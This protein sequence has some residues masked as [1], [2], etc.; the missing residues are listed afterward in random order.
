MVIDVGGIS[1]GILRKPIKNLY[2]RVS[3]S[4]GEVTV[5]APLT[6]SLQTIRTQL[7]AKR[8]WI[9][10][11]HTRV[12]ERLTSSSVTMEHGAIHYF[13]GKSYSL[14]V[15]PVVHLKGIVIEGDCI[16][17]FLE[18]CTQDERKKALQVWYKQQMQQLIPDL[19]KKW[20]PIIGVSVHAWGI[21]AMKTRWGSCNVV[22]HRIWLNLNLIQKPLV[23]LEYVLVHE[24]VHLHE[25]NHSK[26]FYALMTR[27]MPEWTQYQKQLEGKM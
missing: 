10:K 16:H 27:F 20:E 21:R 15:Q 13:L 4:T 14:V 26:R 17:G 11:A 2:L 12:M 19:I 8:D 5:S 22:A 7:D 9:H 24:M 25:A 1:I 18:S 6:L 3:N 23:C